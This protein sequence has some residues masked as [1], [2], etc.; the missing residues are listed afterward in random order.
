MIIL[1]P[2]RKNCGSISIILA[3]PDS[4]TG[5]EERIMA[6][7]QK[8]LWKETALA[9]AEVITDAWEVGK[10]YA[11]RAAEWVLFACMIIN[12][13]E[14]L[15]GISVAVWIMNL[16]LGVQV[17][18]L[19]IGGMS[20]ASMSNHAREQGNAAAASKAD[21]TSKFL[22]GLM[23]VT[24]LLVTIGILFPAMKSYT[25]MAE[26]GLILVRVVMTVIYGHVIHSLRSSD[27]ETYV[28][29]MYIDDVC[30]SRGNKRFVCT[31]GIQTSSVVKQSITLGEGRQMSAVS[32]DQCI[33]GVP[34]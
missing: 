21:T 17:V 2:N 27:V 6:T 29:E 34:P 31:S 26:K 1:L 18:M 5:K 15:P 14:M 20:L 4:R 11:G 24:L 16:V 12:I 9:R 30:T 7:G 10:A 3:L 33:P 8:S 32:I 23:I 19:D 25:D 13:I 28:H 22:I